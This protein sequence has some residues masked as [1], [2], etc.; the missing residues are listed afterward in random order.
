MNPR[1]DRREPEV[2]ASSVRVAIVV[3][4]YNS[5][6]TDRLLQG[7]VEEY[8]RLGG[9]AAPV[10]VHAPGA[11]ELP[12]IAHALAATG[13]YDAV[14][15]LGCVIRGETSHDRH[16]AQAVSGGILQASIATGVPIA[17][18]VLTVETE[19]QAEARAGGKE[20]NKGAEAMRAAVETA[21]T[22]RVV[23]KLS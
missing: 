10:M 18:G 11:F 9:P 22:L 8:S 20:G 12:V 19:E 1:P 6:I 15:A 21:Q 2:D 5:W 17:F 23:Q 13:R 7:A 3:S 14:V 4:R 16:I